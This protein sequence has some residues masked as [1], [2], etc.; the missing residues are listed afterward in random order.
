ME[1]R[2]KMI[3]AINNKRLLTTE[4][5]AAYIGS[6]KG[7]IHTLKCQGKLP[8]QWI[9]PFGKRNIRFDIDEVNKSIEK[10]KNDKS[11]NIFAV[12]EDNI[13]KTQA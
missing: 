11:G 1:K 12:N 10:A 7:S 9:V 3:E 2:K 5:L 6:T 4:E 8:V 13:F